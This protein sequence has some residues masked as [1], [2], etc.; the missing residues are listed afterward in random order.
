MNSNA[1]VQ[2]AGLPWFTAED[3]ESFRKLL[4]DRN[5]HGSFA[6]WEA[7]AEQ[8]FQRIQNQGI[9]PVKAKVTSGEFVAWCAS[10]GRN[11]DTQALL[12]FANEAALRDITGDH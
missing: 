6:E 12:H 9:R 11:V 3:Y 4:P 5:W 2:A 10:T 1:S 7:A 8:T